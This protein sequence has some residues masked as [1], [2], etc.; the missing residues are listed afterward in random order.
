V[1]SVGFLL[2]RSAEAAS[3]AVVYQIT[4]GS[5][6]DQD[7][8]NVPVIGGVVTVNLNGLTNTAST[9][10]HWTHAALL[11][12]WSVAPGDPF[13]MT[14][15][16]FSASGQATAM[17][18]TFGQNVLFTFPFPALLANCANCSRSVGVSFVS[19]YGAFG[20]AL[21]GIGSAVM[22]GTDGGFLTPWR[23]S[24][25]LQEISSVIQIGPGVPEPGVA[26]LLGTAIACFT[27]WTWR[28][29]RM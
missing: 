5:Y 6:T 14:W 23:L 2:P 8:A 11:L 3:A 19:L 20:N 25:G 22:S 27:A 4:G 24:I 17:A 9:L 10:A 29:R 1:W 18:G 26:L 16:S 7:Y 15:A 28:R 12:S 13:Q 21:T